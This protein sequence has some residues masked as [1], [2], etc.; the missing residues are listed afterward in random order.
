MSAPREPYSA[1]PVALPRLTKMRK[2]GSRKRMPGNICV[3]RIVTVNRRLPRK[4]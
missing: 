3:E 4:R 1:M 2:S